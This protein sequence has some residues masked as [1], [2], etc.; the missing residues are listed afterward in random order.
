MSK[1][2][3]TEK[4]K[5]ETNLE[6]KQQDTAKA[7]GSQLEAADLLK[8]ELDGK[9]FKIKR[10]KGSKNIHTGICCIRASFNNTQICFTD[11][12]GN[13]IASSSAGKCHFRGSKKSTAYAA[14]MVT[15]DAAKV[16]MSHG[17]K[18]VVIKVNGPG[19]GRDPSI[20]AVQSIG[21][22]VTDIFD[23][24]PVP[25]NGCRSKKQRRV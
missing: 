14:Q 12:K 10:A 5:P 21:L 13:V 7:A 17:L 15:Q 8:G 19:M 9:E 6:V 20:R 1:E 16:A 22:V 11:H 23:V 4:L 3:I 18:E 2:I 25:H 24:T